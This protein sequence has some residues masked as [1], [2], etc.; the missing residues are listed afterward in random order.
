MPESDDSALYDVS[1]EMDGRSGYITVSSGIRSLQ[2]F[3]EISAVDEYDLLVAE[4]ER[5]HQ[6]YSQL[7][8]PAE[9]RRLDESLQAWTETTGCRC[10]FSISPALR[11]RRWL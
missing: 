4:V 2:M 10:L 6:P 8:S 1:L 11:A 7:L 5:W 3:A 9:L